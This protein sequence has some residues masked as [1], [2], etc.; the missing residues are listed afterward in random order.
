MSR[1]VHFATLALL[2]VFFALI[3]SGCEAFDSPQNTF[4]PKGEVAQK[5]KDD[6]L[7]VMWPALVVGVIVM[8]GL[9]VIALRFRHKKDDRLPKQVHGNTPLELGW[10]IAPAILLAV[11]AVPTLQGIRELS[12][13][14]GNDALRVEVTGQQF[15]WDFA[16]SDFPDS[17]GEA[18]FADPNELRI[19]VDR[20]IDLKI[21]SIDVNHSFW[22]P[23]L[24]GKTDAI[25]NHD[26]RM[27]IKATEVGT[28][29]GQC[30]EFCGLSHSAMRFQVVVMPQDEFDAWVQER[31]AATA[32]GSDAELVSNGD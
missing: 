6:F 16:Y 24:A 26:N 2:L 22:I 18:V 7:F 21:R 27:W 8:A 19:P 9:V 3:L 10:T 29:Q 32:A 25:Q 23:K 12:V 5:Q 4:A 20:V 1:K 14:P 17:A 31:Q 11:I 15:S 30:A 13:V 28:Y